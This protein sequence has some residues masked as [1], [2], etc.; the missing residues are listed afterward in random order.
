MSGIKRAEPNRANDGRN[1]A[2]LLPRTEQTL[3]E[4]HGAFAWRVP[5]L[6]AVN[7]PDA[8]G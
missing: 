4:R 7:G 5:R 8:F 2:L 1:P 3:A 6:R